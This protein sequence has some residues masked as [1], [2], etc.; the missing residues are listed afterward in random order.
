MDEEHKMDEGLVKQ[1]FENGLMG[2]EADPE[3]GGS[4]ANFLTMMIVCEEIS[5]VDPAVGAL[6][7]IHNT[8]VINLLKDLGT[9]EQKE[10]YLRRACTE[11]PAS[12]AIS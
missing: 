8:L 3:Y 5:R 2:V 10:K 4:G 1:L 11:H 12:F 7:D 9:N 6:V